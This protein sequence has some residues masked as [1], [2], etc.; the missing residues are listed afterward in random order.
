MRKTASIHNVENVGMNHNEK[1][2][3]LVGHKHFA[4]RFWEL[5]HL[6]IAGVLMPKAMQLIQMATWLLAASY[7]SI[8][9]SEHVNIKPAKNDIVAQLERQV[10]FTPYGEE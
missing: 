5:S 6:V 1:L 4:F 2:N 10:N 3:E 9:I 8:L 7:L